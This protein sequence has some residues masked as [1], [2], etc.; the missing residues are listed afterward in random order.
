MSKEKTVEFY[1]NTDYNQRLEMQREEDKKIL[2][3]QVK[4]E[5]KE[6]NKIDFEELLKKGNKDDFIY[7]SKQKI[8]DKIARSLIGTVYLAHKKL[9]QNS[10]VS[11]DIKDELREYLKN[12]NMDIYNDILKQ[13]GKV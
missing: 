11:N 4:N 3:S 10:N 8:D 5:E 2:N 9:L 6:Q 13:E 1:K 7:L 12:K